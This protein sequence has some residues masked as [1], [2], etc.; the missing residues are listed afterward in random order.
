MKMQNI[1]LKS[2][3]KYGNQRIF[4]LIELLVVIAIIAI[5][6]SMLLPALNKA[7]EQ[8]KKISCANNLKQLGTAF[9]LYGNDFSNYL[10]PLYSLPS[11]SYDNMWYER[12]TGYLP[13]KAIAIASINDLNT[14][15][16]SI[17]QCPS[18]SLAANFKTNY[19]PN[20]NFIQHPAAPCKSTKIIRNSSR[21]AMLLEVATRYGVGAI[22]AYSGMV[23]NFNYPARV[24]R[25]HAYACISYPHNMTLNILFADAHVEN[26]KCPRPGGFIDIAMDT[27]DLTH[28]IMYE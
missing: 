26:Q 6:A 11:G 5:L 19:I 22:E 7:R 9:A 4:T 17:L 1:T 24:Q 14:A 20:A 18:C 2:S 28:G 27:S 15:T 23:P 25:G 21:T 16:N 8:A 3:R 10:P 12:M 13:Q